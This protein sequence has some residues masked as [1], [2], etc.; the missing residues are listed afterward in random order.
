[1]PSKAIYAA[2]S[3]ASPVVNISAPSLDAAVNVSGVASVAREL[4]GALSN[5]VRYVTFW[6]KHRSAVARSSDGFEVWTAAGL[7]DTY[8]S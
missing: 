1:V 6:S 3:F 7:V 5:K 8:L 4:I 2:K